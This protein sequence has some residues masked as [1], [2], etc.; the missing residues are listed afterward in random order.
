M[1]WCCVWGAAFAAVVLAPLDLMIMVGLMT[2]VCHLYQALGDRTADAQNQIRTTAVFSSSASAIVLFVFSA[3][4]GVL[5]RGPL[6]DMM[7]LSAMI[8]FALFFLLRN[9]HLAW[10][11]T[12]LYYGVVWL[13]VLGQGHALV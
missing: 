13:S 1:A 12:K 9:T 11:L 7:A 8:P 2:A 5:L 10:I 4:I 3:L 6:G